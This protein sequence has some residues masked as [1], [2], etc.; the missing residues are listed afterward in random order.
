MEGCDTYLQYILSCQDKSTQITAIVF[1]LACDRMSTGAALQS[2]GAPYFCS[3]N[4]YSELGTT[5]FIKV[6]L[7][8]L[9]SYHS[10]SWLC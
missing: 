1:S 10:T 2:R 5:W 6:L 7:N 9:P 4:Y 8:I 3:F